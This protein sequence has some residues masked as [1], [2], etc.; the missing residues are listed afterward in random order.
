VIRR[1]LQWLS[2][3]VMGALLAM[4]LIATLHVVRVI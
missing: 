2:L 3:I 1:E 4:A